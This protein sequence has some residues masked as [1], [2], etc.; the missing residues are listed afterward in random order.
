MHGSSYVQSLSDFFPKAIL[1]PEYG[2]TGPRLNEVCCDWTE[3]IM[4][5][6]DYLYRLSI[7]LGGGDASSQSSANE[8]L[9]WRYLL[10]CA[11]CARWCNT[12]C[13]ADYIHS[14]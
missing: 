11:L 1:P 8:W 2:G 10:P 5:S 6:E 12:F 9:Q 7:D 4:Q 13:W 3:Y 14:F